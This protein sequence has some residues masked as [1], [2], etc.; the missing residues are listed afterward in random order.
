MTIC[1]SVGGKKIYKDFDSVKVIRDGG[2]FSFPAKY[3]VIAV[4]KD[5][6]VILYT[7]LSK[8]RALKICRKIKATCKHKILFDG[9]YYA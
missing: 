2:I 8:S 6:I 4:S 1:Y 5:E 3:S 9:I 7:M